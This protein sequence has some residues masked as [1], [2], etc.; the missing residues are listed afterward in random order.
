V[1]ACAVPAVAHGATAT[2]I[3]LP[4]GGPHVVVPSRD[5]RSVYVGARE[6]GYIGRFDIASRSF[7]TIVPQGP[8]PCTPD[9]GGSGRAVFSMVEGPDGR[10]YFTLFDGGAADDNAS[11]VGRVDPDGSDLQTATTGA[12]PLDIVNGPDGNVWFT[13]HG[14]GGSGGRVGRIVP[15]TFDVDVFPVP[16][17]VSGPRGI[18]A[19]PNGSLYVLGGEEDVIWRATTADPPVITEVADAG[20]GLDG[21][22]FGELG[23]DGRIWFA[24]LEGDGVAAF[25]PAT[26]AVDPVIPMPGAPFDVTFGGDGFPY[27]TTTSSGLIQYRRAQDERRIVAGPSGVDGLTF[28]A[29]GPAGEVYAAHPGG[30]RMFD[31]VTDQPPLVRT[32]GAAN[33]TDA[34]ATVSLFADARRVPSQAWIEFGTTESYERGV[35]QISDVPAD[36]GEHQLDFALAFLS[37]STTYHYR[38]HASNHFGQEVTGADATFTTAAAPPFVPPPPVVLPPPPQRVGVVVRARW[39]VHGRR[40]RV[41]SLSVRGVVEREQLEVRCR[42]RG[43]PFARRRVARRAGATSVSLTRLFARRRLRPGAV[44][45]LRITRPGAI[46][47]VVRFT[48]RRGRAPRRTNLCLP[49]GSARPARC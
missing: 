35:T 23:P 27:V 8:L 39:R 49:V 13:V 4:D 15:A 6:C 7:T 12:H 33:V 26:N 9:A 40:T 46:G 11:A 14:A 48:V 5:G 30:D 29:R 3:G 44:I 45:E 19:A 41:R 47:Q 10:I 18:V 21:P 43:C 32:G 25:D 28:A 22:S 1:L 34:T 16:G 36:R 24:Q 37:P 38:A 42:G 31:V 2:P 17:N 20:D